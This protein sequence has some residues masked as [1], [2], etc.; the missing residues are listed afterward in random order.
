MTKLSYQ[1]V[2]TII[3]NIT[4]RDWVHRLTEKGD[5]FLYQVVFKAPCSVNGGEDVVQHSRK[6]YIS[7]WSCR[8][9]I[10]RTV[11]KAIVGAT[12]HEV[13]ENF[14]FNGAA[15]YDPHRDVGALMI[16]QD[17]IDTRQP[18]PEE[19]HART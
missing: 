4:Y 17:N 2:Y 1:Q 14:R 12:L 15:I 5:G 3:Q 7:P 11:Y 13:D 10:V 18:K 19:K 16:V 9:E 6:W 8:S